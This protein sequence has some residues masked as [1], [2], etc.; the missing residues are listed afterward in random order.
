M[1]N[2]TTGGETLGA[3]IGPTAAIGAT[4]AAGCAPPLLIA[5]VITAWISTALAS[6]YTGK[7]NGH[8]PTPDDDGTRLPRG[9]KPAGRGPAPLRSAGR[10]ARWLAHVV[11]ALVCDAGDDRGWEGVQD[12]DSRVP[13]EDDSD[14]DAE[15]DSAPPPPPTPVMSSVDLFAG[16]EDDEGGSG[17]ATPR[18]TPW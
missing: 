18:A 6:K 2:A 5:A 1:W 7:G 3:T 13:H 14:S 16:A 4:T 17:C 10:H 15:A 8:Q 11:P 9:D 12:F